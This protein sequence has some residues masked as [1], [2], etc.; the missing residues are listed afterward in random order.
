MH[1][2]FLSQ[3]LGLIAVPVSFQM[4][5]K[6]IACKCMQHQFKPIQFCPVVLNC[7]NIHI[8]LQSPCWGRS[9]SLMSIVRSI[10]NSLQCCQVCVNHELVKHGHISSGRPKICPHNP[11]PNLNASM[12]AQSKWPV[13]SSLCGPNLSRVSMCVTN[14]SLNRFGISRP[15][16]LHVPCVTA[17]GE[18]LLIPMVG[19]AQPKAG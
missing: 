14:C 4:L 7:K 18:C 17:L 5:D 15:W 10:S 11:A 8:S 13:G 3:V 19:N 12:F 16:W 1:C 2:A 9:K 6:I